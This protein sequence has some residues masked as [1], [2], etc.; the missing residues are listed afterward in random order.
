M[1]RDTN[2][3]V[4][5][6]PRTT[7]II[8]ECQMDS[9]S[10]ALLTCA[11]WNAALNAARDAAWETARD[12]TWDATWVTTWEAGNAAWIAAKNA[13]KD[14]FVVTGH[15]IIKLVKSLG[16]TDTKGLGEKCYQIAECKSLLAINK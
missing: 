11:A 9:M 2:D 7:S 4:W 6:V 3:L 15:D 8:K 1:K 12:A 10:W 5:L 13:T 16:I 14:A